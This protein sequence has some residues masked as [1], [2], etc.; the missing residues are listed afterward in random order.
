MPQELVSPRAKLYQLETAEGQSPDE[1]GYEREMWADN[2]LS[3]HQFCFLYANLLKQAA[4]TAP[5][6]ELQAKAMQLFFDHHSNRYG[7]LPG[8][9]SST[10]ET[11]DAIVVD[12]M[13]WSRTIV[14]GGVGLHL[15]RNVVYDSMPPVLIDITHVG[16]RSMS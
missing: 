2:D 7:S 5:S 8:P 11:R 10:P 12:N 6:P 9:V 4:L 14:L 1:Y 15:S 16:C 3:S 13:V